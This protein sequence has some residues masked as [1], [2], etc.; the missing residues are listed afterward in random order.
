MRENAMTLKKGDIVELKSGGAAMTIADPDYD[1]EDGALC[2]WHDSN[3]KGSYDEKSA[4]YPV[5]ALILQSEKSAKY[6]QALS[7]AANKFR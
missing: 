7:E 1:G 6:T 2:V 3:G 4:T 5:E